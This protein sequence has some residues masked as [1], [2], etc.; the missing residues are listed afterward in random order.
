ML[1]G[2]GVD[3]FYPDLCSPYGHLELVAGGPAYPVSCSFMS[4]LRIHR[5]LLQP[6]A[7]APAHRNKASEIAG[8]RMVRLLWLGIHPRGYKTRR[9]APFPRLIP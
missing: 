5:W 4:R 2:A 3:V 1:L 7:Q 6:R 9:H 8:N